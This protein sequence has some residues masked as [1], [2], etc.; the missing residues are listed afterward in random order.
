MR[1]LGDHPLPAAQSSQ[2][3]RR[4]NAPVRALSSYHCDTIMIDDK[5]VVASDPDD[6]GI[7][8]ERTLVRKTDRPGE[9]DANRTRQFIPRAAR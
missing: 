3:P 1:L 6:C 5:P 2:S 4:M 7:A 8:I 9:C